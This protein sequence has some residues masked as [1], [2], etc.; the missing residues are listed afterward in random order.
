MTIVV[1]AD[2]LGLSPGVTRGI[3]ESHR[4]GIVRSTSLIVTADSSAEAAAQARMEPDLEV[5]L[6][7]DLVGGWPVSDPA[8]VRSLVDAE[9]RFLGLAELTK[10]LFSGRIRA[11]E[12]AAEV[13]A[14]SSVARS[15][16]ILP[17]AWDS[18]RHV[19]L[20]P[21][22]ARVIGRIARDEGVRWVRRARSPRAWTGPK[23][24]ALRA[25]T[26][27][28]A[29]AYRGIPGNRWYIDITSQRPSL[30][31]ASVALLATY[32]GLGEIGAHPGYVDDVLL[33]TDTLT[34]DRPKELEVLTDPLLRT[35]FGSETV[36]W[37]VL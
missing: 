3:L 17:L 30:D 19:H 1:T 5:G 9:G 20:I 4:R 16:G 14:Q 28:S 8:S 13:R 31:A 34:A 24:G 27:M 7:I 21:P 18:H 11:G 23:E 6:H 36:R 32:G 37:R 15:W 35:A 26:F 25:A 12:L 10:R 33:A 22:V 2:D 29:L